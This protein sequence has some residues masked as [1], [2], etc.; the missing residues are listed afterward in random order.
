MFQLSQ[1]NKIISSEVCQPLVWSLSHILWKD[2]CPAIL[3][4]IHK[5]KE[6]KSEV[7]A[8]DGVQLFRL[9]ISIF[10]PHCVSFVDYCSFRLKSI[11]CTHFGYITKSKH[12]D[13]WARGWFLE[14]T[15]VQ[16]WSPNSFASLRLFLSLINTSSMLKRDFK[17]FIWLV[18]RQWQNNCFES[19]IVATKA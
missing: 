14:N 19:T 8:D 3:E 2:C 7:P 5:K 18:V 6:K 9:F 17:K 1:N 16:F 4:F 12:V 10:Q 13:G 11:L 15:A